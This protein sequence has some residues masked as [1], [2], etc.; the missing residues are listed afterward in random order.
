MDLLI[1][2]TKGAFAC[3]S[4]EDLPLIGGHRWYLHTGYAAT[5]LTV[6]GKPK[7]VLMHRVILGLAHGS[8]CDH[9]NGDK[10]DNRRP[11]LRTATP[12]EN[13][14]NAKTRKGREYKGVWFNA[15]SNRYH[16]YIN[17]D[18]KRTSLGH[19]DTPEGAA[20]VYDA[21]ARCL[22]GEFA[23]TNFPFDPS[24]A[25][26]WPSIQPRKR[27]N[28]PRFFRDERSKQCA[29]CLEIKS[30]DEFPPS[31]SRVGDPHDSRC[32]VC[33]GKRRDKYR[34]WEERI[35]QKCSKPFHCDP[36]DI[37]PNHGLFCS[38]SC[39]RSAPRKHLP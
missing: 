11:N 15:R 17:K 25:A 7:T 27:G 5:R 22:F 38:R 33:N 24:V 20:R 26:E 12:S 34:K 37:R 18:G 10:L 4:S 9:A 31:Y 35:C 28:K 1:P 29:I 32:R 16:A 19:H 13:M 14:R 21:A 8:Y 23:R 36:S 6:D 39:A 3:I 30:R 2:L